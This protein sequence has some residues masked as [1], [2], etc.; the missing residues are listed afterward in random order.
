MPKDPVAS[1]LP[2][3]AGGSEMQ[4]NLNDSASIVAWWT[5]FPARHNEH[6]DVLL[7]AR[8]QFACAIRAAKNTIAASRELQALL[9]GSVRDMQEQAA[10]QNEREKS[11]IELRWQE[12]ATAA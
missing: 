6:L 11:S 4:L 3:L 1:L 12:L 5:V 2:A 9:T 8:P 7:A 10:R